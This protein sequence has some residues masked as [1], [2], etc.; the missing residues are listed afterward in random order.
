MSNNW[1]DMFKGSKR[2]P[3]GTSKSVNYAVPVAMFAVVLLIGQMFWV[4]RN[5]HLF[6]PFSIDRIRCEFCGGTGVV[7]QHREGGTLLLCPLC[8]GVGSHHI[9]RIDDKDSLCAACEGMGR[10]SEDGMWRTCRRC[11]GRGLVRDAPWFGERLR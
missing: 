10:L 4:M 2:S 5:E 8:F 11:D 9:R 3:T 6:L 1:Q 7:K